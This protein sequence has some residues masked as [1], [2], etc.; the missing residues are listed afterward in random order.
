[1]YRT[2]KSYLLNRLMGRSDGFPLGSTVQAK[3]KGIWMWLGDHPKDPENKYS[4]VLT[5]FILRICLLSEPCCSWI[6]KGFMTQRRGAR[7]TTLG[8]SLSLF[9]S[10]VSSSTTAKEPWMPMLW[11]GCTWHHS[12]QNMSQ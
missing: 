3:T 8:S 1:M 10:A 11:M 9:S 12:S 2:G 4:F 5:F 6:L 7:L